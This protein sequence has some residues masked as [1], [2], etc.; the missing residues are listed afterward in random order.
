MDKMKRS[1]RNRT[2][3]EDKGGL[4]EWLRYSGRHLLRYL[5]TPVYFV[6]TV[7]P[8]LNAIPNSPVARDRIA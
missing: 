1:Q 6:A 2:G 5:S 3:T 7:S 8:K 4:G